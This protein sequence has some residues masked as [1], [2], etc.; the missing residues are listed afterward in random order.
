MMQI[1]EEDVDYYKVMNCTDR[2]VTQED[3][4]QLKLLEEIR[5]YPPRL[6]FQFIC[7][8]KD[9]AKE[10]TKVEVTMNGSYTELN[11]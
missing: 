3:I 11:H 8:N 5:N 4:D 1:S 2:R 10:C 7:R 9:Q 6:C